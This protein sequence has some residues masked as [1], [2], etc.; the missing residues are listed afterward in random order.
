MHES[1]YKWLSTKK[2]DIISGR[3][4]VGHV[5]GSVPCKDHPCINLKSKFDSHLPTSMPDSDTT[6]LIVG[7]PC[8]IC[9]GYFKLI[10]DHM[11]STVP[12][13]D[14]RSTWY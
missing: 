14:S 7:I 6:L 13:K 3:T 12:C 9:G 4:L 2:L 11:T 5:T 10:V 8:Q 1:P